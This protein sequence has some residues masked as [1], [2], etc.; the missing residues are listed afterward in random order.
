MV[1]YPVYSGPADTMLEYFDKICGYPC[2]PISNPAEFI[3]DLSS[4]DNRSTDLEGNIIEL[5][6][7]SPLF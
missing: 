7:F 3:L 5:L 6:S 4:I 1:G 2:P